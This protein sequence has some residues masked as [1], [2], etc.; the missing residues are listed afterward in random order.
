[1][2]VWS[3]SLAGMLAAVGQESPAPP[4]NDSP[5][6]VE[7]IQRALAKPAPLILDD[8]SVTPTFRVVVREE[9][10]FQ[11]LKLRD[12]SDVGHEPRIPGGLHAFE[13][14]QLQGNPWI[15]QPIITIDVLPMIEAAVEAFGRAH[16]VRAEKAARD[17]VRQ[18]L[19]EFCGTRD[20]SP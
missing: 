16:R 8:A 6:S 10:R 2:L 19:L 7:R 1:M 15:G 9:Q 11:N 5:V 3:I 12:L 20:C 14:R 4:V 13:Q 17:E 18:A